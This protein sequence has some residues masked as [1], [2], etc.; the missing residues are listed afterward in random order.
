[1]QTCPYP[2]F[3]SLLV[4]VTATNSGKGKVQLQFR[5]LSGY[6]AGEGVTVGARKGLICHFP[7]VGIGSLV[8][9]INQPIDLLSPILLDDL[10]LFSIPVAVGDIMADP[11]GRPVVMAAP[12][13]HVVNCIRGFAG[14]LSRDPGVDGKPAAP[15]PGF[16]SI[17]L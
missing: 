9:G 8:H 10:G 5:Y 16:G 15:A 14:V 6:P 3:S 11:Q 17:N 1:M 2:C 13:D 4:C 7:G 12:T